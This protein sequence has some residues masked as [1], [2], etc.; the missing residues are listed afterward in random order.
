MTKGK[1]KKVIRD[2]GFG[3]IAAIDGREIFFHRSS[4]V[5]ANFDSISEGTEVEFD[6]E[7]TPKGP[8]AINVKVL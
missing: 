7:K 1:V 5:D 4:L 8:R 2:K 3:F 6:T